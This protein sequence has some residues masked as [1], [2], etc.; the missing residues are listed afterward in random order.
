MSVSKL[1]HDFKKKYNYS[2]VE[3]IL[4]LKLSYAR[5]YMFMTPNSRTADVAYLCGFNDVGYFCRR[6]KKRY[7][8]TPKEDKLSQK[9]VKN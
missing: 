2:V 1:C 4:N 9:F 8:K 7:G 6:Y 5:N 3:Y